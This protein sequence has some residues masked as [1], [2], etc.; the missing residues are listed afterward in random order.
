M[1]YEGCSEDYSQ[2]FSHART[3]LN[4]AVLESD[5]DSEVITKRIIVH[6]SFKINKR[7]SCKN[8]S[9]YYLKHE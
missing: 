3:L 9:K 8:I 7:T 6:Y 5:P 1:P 2:R 4:L